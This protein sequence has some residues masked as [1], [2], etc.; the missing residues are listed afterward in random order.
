MKTFL[1]GGAVRD[2]LLKRKVKDRDFVVV[3]ATPDEMIEV[4]FEQ[5]GAD[6]PVFLHPETKDEHA[7]ARTERKTGKGYNGFETSFDTSVTLE[8]DL[9]RR[10]LTINAMAIDP[11]T[12]Q[13]IDPHNGQQDLKDGVLRHVSD[14]FAEDPLRVLRVA[15]FAA[16][17]GFE[18]APET[19]ELMKKLVDEGELEHLTTERVWSELERALMEDH[20]SKFIWTLDKCGALPVLFPELGRTIID[21]CYALTNAALR[22]QTATV[23]FAALLM[24][25]PGDKA[26]SFA[27]RVG[28][29][30]EIKRVATKIH[31]LFDLINRTS[32]S[33]WDVKPREVL[34][35]LHALKA[36]QMP[37]VLFDMCTAVD[38]LI[39]QRLSSRCN[40]IMRAA[41]M[42]KNINFSSLTQEQQDTLKGKDIA[43]AI[44][45][46]R[47]QKL[48]S[49]VWG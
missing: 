35:L 39:R 4:G 20:P 19:M 47:E 40:D 38:M 22:N 16:R 14:A 34:D 28:M 25:L 31:L 2:K 10:D 43:F 46:L 7:L 21:S 42:T 37:D 13:V 24:F 44:A 9:I 41:W 5:V 12:E 48:H 33:S 30:N 32:G 18:V 27:D 29:P 3:G 17:Y 8:D 49:I 23:R 45:D 6:F 26:E 11:D 15:R 1:V 36:Y